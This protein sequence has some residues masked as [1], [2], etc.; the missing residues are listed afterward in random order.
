MELADLGRKKYVSQS[1]LSSVLSELKALDHVPD[2]TSRPTIKRKREEKMDITTPLGKVFN[3]IP[4]DCVDGS[5]SLAVHG[6][7]F[8][9]FMQNFVPVENHVNIKDISEI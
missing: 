4:L 5:R 6:K 2:A 1:A 3:V 9:G 8:Y 7:F